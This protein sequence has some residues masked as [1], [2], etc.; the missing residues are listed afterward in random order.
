M[1][2]KTKNESS[3]AR[4]TAKRAVRVACTGAAVAAL[5]ADSGQAKAKARAGGAQASAGQCRPTASAPPAAANGKPQPVNP[6]VDRPPSDK[7][8]F[9]EAEAAE[10]HRPRKQSDDG[11][12]EAKPKKPKYAHRDLPLV[13]ALAARSKRVQINPPAGRVR[14]YKFL[15]VE[16]KIRDWIHHHRGTGM[17][18]WAMASLASWIINR[19][20]PYYNGRWQEPKEDEAYLREHNGIAWVVFRCSKCAEDLNMSPSEIR[21]LLEEM[22]G[23]NTK[24]IVMGY[25]ETEKPPEGKRWYGRN[26]WVVRVR[27][28]WLGRKS[29]KWKLPK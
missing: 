7:P 1:R 9:T 10:E 11:G 23:D 19:L 17:R 16:D 8:R 3:P 22:V 24:G 13:L 25:K 18:F 5:L 2:K 26:T 4:E 29:K 12:C 28:E 15:G 21:H 6:R 27:Y 14:K 20:R